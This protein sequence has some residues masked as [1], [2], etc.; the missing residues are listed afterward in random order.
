MTSNHPTLLPK[1]KIT[2]ENIHAFT[3]LLNASFS[4]D[5]ADLIENKPFREQILIFN[6]LSEKLTVPVFEYL[7]FKTQKKILNAL[8]SERIAPLLN[9]MSPD[10][11]TAL[12]EALPNNLVNQLLK[13]LSPEERSLSIKLLGYPED[14][15]GRLMTPDYIAIKLEWTVRQVLDYIREKG[16]DSETINVIYAVD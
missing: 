2:A 10:D 3:Q 15:V 8:P 4:I 5:L 13:Y 14:S 6:I 9:A 11:R 1:I 16:H 7:S 12:L